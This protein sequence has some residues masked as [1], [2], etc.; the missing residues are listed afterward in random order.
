M[1]TKS[2]SRAQV[3]I[4]LADC[5]QSLTR[6]EDW[7][8]ARCAK[9]YATFSKAARRRSASGRGGFEYASNGSLVRLAQMQ[10]KKRSDPALESAK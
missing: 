9:L 4:P 8:T 5:R 1:L 3:L 7:K 2:S 6:P 10:C